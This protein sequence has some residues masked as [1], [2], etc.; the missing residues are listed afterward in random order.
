[1]KVVIDI[2]KDF[3]GD[4]IADKFKDFFSRVIADI[5]CKG[6]CGRYEKEI[7]EMF[8][9]AFDDSEEKISCN[10]QHN[11]NSRDNE[12]CCRCDSITA[13]INKA[14]VNSLEIIARMLDDK[15]YYE[16]KYRQVGKKDYSIGY[17]SYDLKIVLGYIDTY[18]EIVESDKQTNADRIRIM[19]D[20]ELSSFLDNVFNNFFDGFEFA[21]DVCTERTNC[22]T[23][24]KEWLQS[25]AE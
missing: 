10:C 18:F 16:L 4:Y 22:E 17:S 9:K 11:S 23:C 3:T 15:P 1:M 19:S 6:M 12:N 20:E 21:C 24:F 8:L 2:P 5:D 13:N 25:E 14:K 7:A